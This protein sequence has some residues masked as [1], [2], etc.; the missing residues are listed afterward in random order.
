MTF[1][2][3]L[4]YIVVG[5]IIGKIFQTWIDK[6]SL[7]HNKLDLGGFVA[8]ILVWPLIL[9]VLCVVWITNFVEWVFKLGK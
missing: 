2:Y 7:A 5:F 6:G 9:V 8:S 1:I 4:G 3:I